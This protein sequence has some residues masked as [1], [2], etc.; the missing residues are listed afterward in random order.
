[1]A[2][3]VVVSMTLGIVVDDTVH[4]LSKYLRAR[5]EKGYSAEQAVT[6]AFT[7]VGRALIVSTIVLMVGF[8]VLMTSPFTM[9]SDMAMLT[10]WIICLALVVD[11]LLLPVLLL[12]FDK[13][14]K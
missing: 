5:R 13:G 10:T 8:G 1:M 9:N 14:E 12:K 3:A 7:H 2:L 4:F 6:Y 11:F